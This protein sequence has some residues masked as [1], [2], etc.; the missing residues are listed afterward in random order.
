ME[1]KWIL[2]GLHEMEGIGRK[3]IS[4][5][6]SGEHKLADMLDFRKE[7]WIKAGLRTDQ[8]LRLV[9]RLN[10]SWIEER[11][12]KVYK[13][14]IRAITY[15]DCEYPIL[16]KETGSP[17]WVLYGIG[18]MGLL[19]SDSIAMVGTRMPT[20]YGRKIG[21][22]L[23]G[24]LCHAGL[25]VVSGLARGI[26]SVCHEAA[27]RAGGKT[28]AVFGTGIDQIYPAENRGLAAKI[29]EQGLLLSEYPPGTKARQGLFPERNRIIA[30]LSLGT[31]VV[32]ADLR[33]GSLITADAALE[34][35]RDVFAVPGPITSPKSRGAHNLIRQGAKLV[36]SVTDLL[37]EYQMGL[38]NPEQLPYNR[39][40]STKKGEVI[41]QAIF[42]ETSLSSDE[43]RVITLLEHEEQ[44][45]DQLVEQLGWDFGHLH[46]VLLSLIIKKQINQLPGS[47]YV[48]V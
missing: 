32:E 30:G 5:L 41:A 7:D 37:E 46:S 34:A 24:D 10:R 43:R 16:L 48:R 20:V 33:S 23:A 45:L 38:P 25:T 29:A 36:T 27:L 17:P 12:E 19:C 18:D 44:S 9:E 39:G 6:M 22:K 40:R 3:T 31:L 26:D 35:G 8:A 4:K 47:R 21:E 28:I 2:F 13:L 42:P 11:R 14:G 15:L 1:D